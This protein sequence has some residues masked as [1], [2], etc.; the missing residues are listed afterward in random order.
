[1]RARAICS[2]GIL[3]RAYTCSPDELVFASL[4]P[5]R[6]QVFRSAADKE[7]WCRKTRADVKKKKKQVEKARASTDV[8]PARSTRSDGRWSCLVYPNYLLSRQIRRVHQLRRAFHGN[9]LPSLSFF[10]FFRRWRTARR[11]AAEMHLATP[12]LSTSRR[13]TLISRENLVTARRNTVALCPH[14]IMTNYCVLRS[15]YSTL[16]IS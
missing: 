2:R 12:S 6:E 4:H 16:H 14:I 8:V 11:N 5:P 15:I 3:I 10:I 1:M 9:F 13:Y 7:D